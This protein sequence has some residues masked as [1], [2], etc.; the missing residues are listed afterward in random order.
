VGEFKPQFFP[1]ERKGAF[2]YFS[3]NFPGEGKTLFS[4]TGGAK[5]RVFEGPYSFLLRERGFFPL[6]LRSEIEIL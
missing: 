2:Y 3:N 4:E 6:F 5:K 1:Q